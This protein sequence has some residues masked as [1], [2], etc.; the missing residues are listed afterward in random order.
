MHQNR[1]NM[2]V[3]NGESASQWD[4]MIESTNRWVKLAQE[5]PWEAFADKY[6]PF[7][8]D[9]SG[10][11]G[12]QVRML[13][14]ALIIKEKYGFT[15]RETIDQIRENP[16]L[17]YFIG[18]QQFTGE[19]P[20]DVTT[21]AD[22]R[23]KLDL[24]TLE[25]MQYWTNDDDVV[26]LKQTGESQKKTGLKQ[27]YS[28]SGANGSVL[29]ESLERTLEMPAITEPET[30][31]KFN[32]E[33]ISRSFNRTAQLFRESC[34]KLNNATENVKMELEDKL[35]D[36]LNARPG[37]MKIPEKINSCCQQGWG[38]LRRKVGGISWR[39]TVWFRNVLIVGCTLLLGFILLLIFL[40]VP[41]PRMLMASEVYDTK[42]RLAATFYSENRRPVKLDEIP[43]FLRQA[44][45]AI[46]DHRFY[47]HSGINYGR[48]LKAAWHD[49]T[50]GSVEQG[51]STITQQLVK[52]VYLT[53]ERTFSRK[54]QEL[55][56][57]IKLEF[58]LSKDEIF[59]LY[60]NKIYFGHGAYGVK[61]A[62]ET[63]FQKDLSELNE[64]EMAMLAG[65]PRG[66]SYYSPYKHPKAARTRLELVLSRMKECGF[67]TEIQYQQCIK[68]Q[69]TLPGVKTRNNAAPYF[70][71]MLQNEIARLFPENPQILYTAGVKIESTIDLDLHRAALKAFT[72][73]LP[74]IYH[75]KGGIPQP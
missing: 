18:L 22:F 7:V 40:P 6:S 35:A 74:V 4:L 64:A 41:A 42:H 70:M 71:D 20:F 67:I 43:L 13:L 31:K 54:F 29:D 38:Y 51:G 23:R 47:K 19:L 37:L 73:G 52:N 48:I 9:A 68:E 21:M 53:H 59:E 66:P 15:D 33:M 10:T 24:R 58:K 5:V 27:E 75:R 45:L 34:G 65:L 72:Q 2:P 3:G 56:F 30:G 69:L 36:F 62:A 11:A 60:L 17:Q 44:V 14:G 49:L 46:E 32:P 12:E 25:E 1:R 61:V 28:K 63:Y 57:S 26:Q 16:Y 50:H 39:E 8:T 55:L